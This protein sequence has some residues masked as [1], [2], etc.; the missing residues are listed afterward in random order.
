MAAFGR[1]DG[2]ART[3]LID[4]EVAPEHRRKGYG[5]HLVAEILRQAR[6]QWGEV[7]SVQT[8]SDQRP[9]PRPLPVARLRAGRTGHPLPTPGVAEADRPVDLSGRPSRAT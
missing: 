9:G 2:R 8:R 4:V 3:G 7:V 6:S 5:R 1:L